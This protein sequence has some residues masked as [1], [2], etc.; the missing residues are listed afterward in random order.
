[1]LPD[2]RRGFEEEHGLA[3][4]LRMQGMRMRDDGVGETFM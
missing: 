4:M 3:M 2:S 1:M